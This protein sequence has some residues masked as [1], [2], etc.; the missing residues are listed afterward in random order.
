[1]EEQKMERSW[2]FELLNESWYLPFSEPPVTRDNT[3]LCWQSHFKFSFLLFAAESTLIHDYLLPMC[4]HH[5]VPSIFHLCHDSLQVTSAFNFL[6]PKHSIPH[7]SGLHILQ[8]L[9]SK[10]FFVIQFGIKSLL[11]CYIIFS[12]QHL[13]FVY[14]LLSL[15]DFSRISVYDVEILTFMFLTK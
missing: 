13:L 9:F 6:L 15:T 4:P 12:K 2:L 8:I 5:V 7:F 10:I 3:W 14:F 1:M 11:L